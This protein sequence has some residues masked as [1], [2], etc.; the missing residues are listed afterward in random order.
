MDHEAEVGLVEAHA[1]CARRHQS[2]ELVVLEPPLELFALVGV[3][4]PRVGTHLVTGLPQQAR[5]VLGRRHGERVD[6]AAARHVAQVTQQPAETSPRVGQLEHAQPQ[7]CTGQ[8]AADREHLTGCAELFGDV[9]DHALVCCC[10]RGEHWQVSR[11]CSN[12]LSEATVVGPEVVTP[13]GDAVRLVDDEHAH[14]CDQVGQLLVAEPGVVEPLRRDQQD[15]DLVSG[16]LGP[17]LVP[18]VG[19]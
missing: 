7:R 6:D 12:E 19:I 1:E 15:I 11:Q 16:Q 2:L 10:R 9:D 8:R 5:S 4:A 3:R 18:L 14:P 17:G 13:V